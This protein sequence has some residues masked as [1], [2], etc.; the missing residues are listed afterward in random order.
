MYIVARK[1][2]DYD[3]QFEWESKGPAKVTGISRQYGVTLSFVS[4][5]HTLFVTVTGEE[6]GNLIQEVVESHIGR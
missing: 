6:L 3:H 2:D 5:S 1:G 4:G